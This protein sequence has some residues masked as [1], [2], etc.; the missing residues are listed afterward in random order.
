MRAP[1]EAAA[2]AA[3][4]RSAATGRAGCFLLGEGT[5]TEAGCES[6]G[7][8]GLIRFYA[9]LAVLVFHQFCVQTL[10][11]FYKFYQRSNETCV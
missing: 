8:G 9:G 1:G 7:E 2:A 3:Q 10:A 5:G 4:A 6:G 11:V